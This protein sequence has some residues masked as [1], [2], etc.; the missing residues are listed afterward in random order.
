MMMKLMLCAAAML[1]MGAQSHTALMGGAGGASGLR[2]A[3][4]DVQVGGD[5]Y[6][7]SSLGHGV[8][9]VP[10]SLRLRGGAELGKGDKR[11]IVENR[12]DGKNVGSWHWEE[13]DMLTWTKQRL[14][15]EL[16]G[17][18]VEMRGA[19]DL[20]LSLSIW[21]CQFGATRLVPLRS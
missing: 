8:E 9:R 1:A 20:A 16:L 7:G 6:R 17:L 14:V 10:T 21:S 18:T 5:A 15:E 12:Q 2:L 3:A 13:R 4:S 19:D 11:W